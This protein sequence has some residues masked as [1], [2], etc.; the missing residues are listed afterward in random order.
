MSG[1]TAGSGGLHG[2]EDLLARDRADA[3]AEEGVVED[4][5]HRLATAD[6]CRAGQH[7]LAD[8]TAGTAEPL[9]RLGEAIGHRQQVAED[10]RVERDEGGV[11]L[12]E[13]LLIDQQP[14]P[15]A[16]RDGKVAMAA[17]TDA[18]GLE[19][20]RAGQL[21]PT[22]RAGQR[23]LAEAGFSV[24]R[25]ARFGNVQRKGLSREMRVAGAWVVGHG[26]PPRWLTDGEST[27]HL[28]PRHPT[29]PSC[30]RQTDFKTPLPRCSI[31]ASVAIPFGI[32]WL[33]APRL[34]QP[35]R[36]QC[37]GRRQRSAVSRL[38]SR[39]G[40]GLPPPERS[41]HV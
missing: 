38:P 19:G 35:V 9:R 30:R 24:G 12:P 5:D 2:E 21:D 27:R 18:E 23:L 39:P 32:I 4:D 16:G 3:G 33:P 20:V 17:G 8:A 6:R 13:A 10:E 37:G 41:T 36:R 31:S 34:H 29:H 1:Q 7:R 25:D 40:D 11:G 28:L 22:R 14:Q 15:L 26:V